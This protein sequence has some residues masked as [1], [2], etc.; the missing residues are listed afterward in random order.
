MRGC[1]GESIDGTRLVIE[2]D[3]VVQYTIYIYVRVGFDVGK[4]AV[5]SVIKM[6]VGELPPRIYQVARNIKCIFGPGDRSR[7]GRFAHG[8]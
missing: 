3:L 8:M 4:A 2:R 5:G 7:K 1:V 6:R